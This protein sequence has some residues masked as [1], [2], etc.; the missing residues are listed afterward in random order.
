MVLPAEKKIGPRY[1]TCSNNATK[2]QQGTRYVFA[3]TH[4]FLGNTSPLASSYHTTKSVPPNF[5]MPQRAE[6]R[7]IGRGHEFSRPCGGSSA[8]DQGADTDGRRIGASERRVGSHSSSYWRCVISYLA[9]SIY[10]RVA[11]GCVGVRCYPTP[12]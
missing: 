10:K 11:C 1:V 7:A 8:K 12:T 3:N 9:P 4:I 5:S 6:G 2:H